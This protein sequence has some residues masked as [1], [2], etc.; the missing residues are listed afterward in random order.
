MPLRDSESDFPLVWL[1][2][3]FSSAFPQIPGELS[4][5]DALMLRSI[6]DGH[7]EKNQ[8]FYTILMNQVCR[9]WIKDGEI[10]GT[11]REEDRY[12]LRTKICCSVTVLI[13]F[14][15]F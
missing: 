7:R 6:E 5:S 10:L 9:E 4:Y 1:H 12:F 14:D 8:E 11:E 2:P 15:F 13:L 3:E